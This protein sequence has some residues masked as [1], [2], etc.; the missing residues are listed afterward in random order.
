MQIIETSIFTRRVAALLSEDEYRALQTALVEN[1]AAGALIVGTG[2]A[3][4]VRWAPRGR[5]KSGGVRVIY[6]WANNDGII[7]MLMIYPKNEQDTLTDSQKRALRDVIE[8]S[9]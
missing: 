2:G 3:R 4:K 9:G 5:G 1:A 7:L 8:G 6:Y